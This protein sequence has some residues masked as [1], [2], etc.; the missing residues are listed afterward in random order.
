MEKFQSAFSVWSKAGKA[1]RLR[2]IER[3]KKIMSSLVPEI[4]G[5]Q[6]F[7]NIREIVA[8][9]KDVFK[10]YLKMKPELGGPSIPI[11]GPANGI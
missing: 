6:I 9:D 5:G 1:S 7:R 8:R 10:T 3:R 2:T 11:T 4:Y